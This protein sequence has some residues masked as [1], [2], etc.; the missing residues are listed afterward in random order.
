[1]QFEEKAY[2]AVGLSYGT[3]NA[4]HHLVYIA[5][6]ES[7]MVTVYLDGGLVFS[8]S[9]TD[10]PNQNNSWEGHTLKI[11]QGISNESFV[12]FI[13][14][15]GIWDRALSN[16]E[17]M[18]L[19]YGATL[20]PGCTD[21]SAC[22]FNPEANSDDGTCVE[23]GCTDPAACN[24]NPEAGC[25]DGSCAP[26]DAVPG[27]MEAAAC[28]YDAAAVCAAQC[29]YPPA[30]S[31]DCGA[32]A[33]F[34]GEG[35]VWDAAAQ[36]CVIHPDYL[37]EMQANAAQSACGPWTVWDAATGQCVGTLSSDCPAD[38]NGNGFVGV[39]DLLQLLSEFATDCP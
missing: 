33:A 39:E 31:A 17:V 23:A 32:G 14:D 2:N 4:W 11:G 13:D 26:A 7:G 36:T 28:N 25:D 5:N 19:C 21:E 38:V 12:G 27:C 15:F 37:L 18:A 9:P 34:C 3:D 24:F 29:V 35:M 20:V 30:G 8:E 10:N 1:M 6:P 22:N 16:D